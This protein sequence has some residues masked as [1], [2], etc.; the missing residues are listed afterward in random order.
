MISARSVLLLAKLRLSS[1]QIRRDPLN[2]ELLSSCKR[3]QQ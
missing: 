1:F 2:P 3:I